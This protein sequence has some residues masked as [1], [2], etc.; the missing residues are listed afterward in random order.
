MKKKV[1]IHRLRDISKPR[2]IRSS[3]VLSFRPDGLGGRESET[4][5]IEWPVQADTRL[6]Q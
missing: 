1:A 2:S 5:A 3:V 4:P 6:P